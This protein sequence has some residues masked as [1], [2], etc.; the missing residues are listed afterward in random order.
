M[1]MEKEIICIACPI[2]C[3]MKVTL[4]GTNIIK[5]EGNQCK[6]GEKYAKQE[7]ILPCRVLT[8]TVETDDPL[9]P[10]LPVRSDGEIPFT[11]IS[12]CMKEIS[13]NKISGS[14]KRGKVLIKNI[15]G[16]NVNIIACRTLHTKGKRSKQLNYN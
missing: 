4:D 5:I 9:I 13:K 1:E 15:I 10:L 16:S 7:A 2:G 8:T 3:K 11:K 12:E 14:V 6:N